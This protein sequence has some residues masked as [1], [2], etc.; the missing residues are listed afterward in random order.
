MERPYAV[1]NKKIHC[2]FEFLHDFKMNIYK[3]IP[4][5]NFK[6]CLVKAISTAVSTVSNII[7]FVIK[8]R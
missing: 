2:N 8:K 7:Y 4:A 5:Q 3:Q 6:D 1:I